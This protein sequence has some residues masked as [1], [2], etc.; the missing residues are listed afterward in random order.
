MGEGDMKDLNLSVVIVL[1]EKYGIEDLAEFIESYA[2][3]HVERNEE[4]KLYASI[5][6]GHLDR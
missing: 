6:K 1:M 2:H 5:K 3:L 4:M